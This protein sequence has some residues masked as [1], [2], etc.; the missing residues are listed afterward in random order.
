VDFG[1]LTTGFL[2]GLREGVEAALI[3]AIV[4]AYVVRTGNGRHIPTIWLGAGSAAIVS[5]AI[6]LLI[7]T[8]VGSFEEPYEQL[9]EGST[10][11][12]AA[13]VVTWM[14]FWMRRQSM[15]LR[16]ELHAAVD[17]VLSSGGAWG[18]AI[19][20]F[21]AVIREGVETALFLAGQATSADRSAGSVGL[22]AV[23]GLGAAV[24]IG[25][26]F[27]RGSRRIDLRRFFRWTGIALVFIAAG[28]LS[29]AIHELL[30]VAE[31]A[32]VAIVGSQTA[33]DISA[34]LSHEQGIGQFLRAIFG[35]SASP[36][37]L[38]LVVH[39]TYVVGV[40]ALYLR[41]VRVIT[42]PTA[43]QNDPVSATS[44]RPG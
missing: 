40:L 43:P 8:T 21:T 7:F 28:L 39:V 10:M 37:V 15:H 44:P 25:W 24:L 38:T 1:A 41:P 5:L 4:L 22:G 42:P 33:F 32:G 18:L 20:A 35:Y 26:G 12:L 16:G 17:K 2:I 19:L 29:H 23:V 9:F 27:Y 13:V 34:F 36:E 31:I 3:V 14:L 30:E 6:G 11:L